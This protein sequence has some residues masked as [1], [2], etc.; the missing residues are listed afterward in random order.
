MLSLIDLVFMNGVMHTR[1]AC[2]SEGVAPNR[3]FID[4]KIEPL[5]VGVEF[6]RY[7]GEIKN[8]VFVDDGTFVAPKGLPFDERGLPD[9]FKSLPHKGYRVVKEIPNVKKGA[10]I[11]WFGKVGKG[12]QHELPAGID[13]LITSGHIERIF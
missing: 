5:A 3:G 9:T 8:G 10:S 13:E 1:H 12:Q 7:G 2:A 11:P 6:D 4:V